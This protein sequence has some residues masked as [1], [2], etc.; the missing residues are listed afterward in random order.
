MK[1]VKLLENSCNYNDHPLINILGLP[2]KRLSISMSCYDGHSVIL[3]LKKCRFPPQSL[4]DKIANM[5][6]LQ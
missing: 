5:M 1:G 2:N 4:F 6:E 3:H